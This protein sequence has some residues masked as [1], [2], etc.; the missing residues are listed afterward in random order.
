VKN[1]NIQPGEV[2]E[3]VNKDSHWYGKTLVAIKEAECDDWEVQYENGSRG[4]RNLSLGNYYRRLPAA[5]ASEAPVVDLVPVGSEWTNDS[6]GYKYRIDGPAD[7]Y[8]NLPN[9][10]WVRDHW[11]SDIMIGASWFL[12]GCTR[13]DTPAPA[14]SSPYTVWVGNAHAPAAAPQPAQEVPF[15]M[16]A[17]S[18]LAPSTG[19]KCHIQGNVVLSHGPHQTWKDAV[20]PAQEVCGYRRKEWEVYGGDGCYLEPG[21]DGGH[22][23]RAGKPSQPT[24]PPAPALPVQC[25]RCDLAPLRGDWLTCRVCGFVAV[26]DKPAPAPHRCIRSQPSPW[27]KAEK[28]CWVCRGGAERRVLRDRG[29]ILTEPRERR[30]GAIRTDLPPAGRFDSHVPAIERDWGGG[31]W[32]R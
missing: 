18:G 31:R 15:G 22:R 3:V 21:H 20:K 13:I 16:R 14:A 8:G 1:E 28:P 32:R 19:H 4:L 7:K 24:P 23:M 9:S 26:G 11:S 6:T 29:P 10:L 27:C 12:E 17:S 5:P 30:A 2:F 25:E